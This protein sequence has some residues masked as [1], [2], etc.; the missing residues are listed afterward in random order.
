[1][2]NIMIL[3]A[4]RAGKTTLARL[5]KKE[6]QNY[7]ILDWDCV[8]MAFER[9]IP[10]LEINHLNGA[11]MVNT[12]PQFCIELFMDQIE[13]Q[14]NYFNYI[15]ES[16]GIMPNHIKKYLKINNVEIIF[17]WYPKLTVEETIYN[18]KTYAQPG[19]YML[20]KNRK[21]DFR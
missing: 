17:L 1:M 7:C 19:D 6:Y 14:E 5:I 11:G 8:R 16:C 13:Y 4:A 12:F 9:V 21:W 18:Y 15:F 2:K 20:K 3:W 10:E